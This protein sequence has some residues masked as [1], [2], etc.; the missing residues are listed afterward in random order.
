MQ[1]HARSRT[2]F[3][4]DFIGSTWM[5]PADVTG[6]DC[7]FSSGEMQI[8]EVLP[9]SNCTS[10]HTPLQVRA[11]IDLLSTSVGQPPTSYD[12]YKRMAVDD[13]ND[14]QNEGFML[15]HSCLP[16]HSRRPSNKQ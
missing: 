13:I 12:K 7:L 3:Q 1:W 6:K 16:D 10:P 15:L 8:F 5:F 2:R 14:V 4:N 11:G 9:I